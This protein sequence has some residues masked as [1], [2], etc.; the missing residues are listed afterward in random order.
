MHGGPSPGAP[1]G[2]QNALKHGLNAAATTAKEK[3][4]IKRRSR[5]SGAPRGAPKG[6]Q[7]ALKHWRYTAEQLAEARACVQLILES[8]E[9]MKQAERARKAVLPPPVPTKGTEHF[10]EEDMLKA[11]TL[12]ERLFWTYLHI[13]INMSIEQ[14]QAHA[15]VKEANHRGLEADDALYEEIRKN[16]RLPTLRIPKR[17]LPG[18]ARLRE[19]AK[20]QHEQCR[21]MRNRPALKRT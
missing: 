3:L 21:T 5:R 8:Q 15:L 13:A 4:L 7:N 20:Q 17:E 14:Q 10:R 2:N 9:G 6:N 18:L 12:R 16:N 1:K 19:K 11:H